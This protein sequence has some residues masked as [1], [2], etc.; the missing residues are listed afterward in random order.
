MTNEIQTL[1]LNG[2]QLNLSNGGGSV[3]LPGSNWSLNN[4]TE[5]TSTPISNSVVIGSSSHYGSK[6]YVA[7]SGIEN[8]GNF[9]A[10][11][12]GNALMAY[13]N[14]TGTGI[15]ASSLHGIGANFSSVDG[16]ALI[17]GSGNVGIGLSDP[18]HKLEVN[19]DVYVSNG[20]RSYSETD[21]AARFCSNAKEALMIYQ[22][23][24][25]YHGIR[26]IEKYNYWHQ[27]IDANGDMGW[28]YNDVEKS[29]FQHSDGSFHNSSD[30]EL[31][32]D[33]QPF[34]NVLSKLTQ[35]QAYTYHMKDAADDSPVS[36]GFM[37]QEVEAQFPALVTYKNGYRSL[38][39]DHFAVLS[40][41]AIKEQQKEIE[42]QKSIIQEQQNEIDAL[43]HEFDA[44]KV[45]VM[46]QLKK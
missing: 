13:N 41:Q 28:K 6:L 30:R 14:S 11:G 15:S 8:G 24:G 18:D 12:T 33:I 44:L 19:G 46:Q 9:L 31:K 26:F 16:Y 4:G 29:W 38:C 27:A 3:Q 25:Q 36:V 10:P 7:S 5:I 43:H 37:A 21:W 20:I 34:S 22:N 35:L 2:N 45:L 32:K 23:A 39:Y 17:T 42:D 40:V 1:S